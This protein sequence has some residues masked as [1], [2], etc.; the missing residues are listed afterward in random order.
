[1]RAQLIACV[2]IGVLSG[3]GFA[4]LGNPYAILL[5]VIAGVLE[6]VPLMGPLA[7]AVIAVVIAALHD[8]RLAVWTAVFLIALRLV[9]DY[10]IYPRLI[11]RDIHLHPLVVIL[12]VLGGAELDGIAGVFIAVPLVAL[13]TVAG[14]HWLEWRGHDAEAA[15]AAA[16][17]ESWS[18]H[19][20]D[21]TRA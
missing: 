4:L 12:A 13:T 5:G 7:V 9:E 14:R 11:G 10:V 17:S 2:L 6:V 3:A 18:P 16:D 15:L 20:L 1:M 21:V 8:P 19:G